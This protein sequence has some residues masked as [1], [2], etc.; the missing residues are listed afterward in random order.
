MNTSPIALDVVVTNLRHNPQISVYGVA[1]EN[2]LQLALN[3]HQT[4]LEVMLENY[5]KDKGKASTVEQKSMQAIMYC[6]RT[7]TELS[8]ADLAD[9]EAQSQVLSSKNT[10]YRQY[11]FLKRQLD[12]CDLVRDML[13]IQAEFFNPNGS[14]EYINLKR[15]TGTEA[16]KRLGYDTN[17]VW[18][19][20][21]NYY[22]WINGHRFDPKMFFQRSKN[23]G[24]I[25][26]IANIIKS[27]DAKLDSDINLS[28][29]Y[30]RVNAMG[31]S[32]S[33][34]S[35]TNKAAAVVEQL[36]AHGYLEKSYK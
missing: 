5:Q 11:L 17:R 33:K 15:N 20:N 24:L 29:I 10:I 13:N 21:R 34:K 3:Q 23:P 32:E 28:E 2:D 26:V 36:V 22:L 27:S 1:S 19:A 30:R 18:R 25:L 31:F 12:K 8:E 7:G 14:F 35:V 16:A 6:L 4:A 9:Y